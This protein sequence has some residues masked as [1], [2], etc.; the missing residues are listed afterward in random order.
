[1]LW[2]KY[3]TQLPEIAFN[4]IISGEKDFDIGYQGWLIDAFYEQ[5]FGPLGDQPHFPDKLRKIIRSV[6]H[7]R[8]I[9]LYEWSK[10]CNTSYS[11]ATDFDPR[12]GE[13][14]ALEIVRQFIAELVSQKES[15]SGR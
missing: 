1:M 3:P 12:F 6:Q 9:S 11:A 2:L 8:G 13:W 5:L 10:W 14:T 4:K 15:I 7:Q